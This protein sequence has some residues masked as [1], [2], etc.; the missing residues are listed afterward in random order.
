MWLIM[1]VRETDIPGLKII[2]IE[3]RCDNRGFFARSFCKEE[4]IKN[5]LEHEIVQCNISHNIQK[6]TLRGM[7]YQLPPH[8]EIKM[9]RC[10][11]GAIFDVVVDLRKDSA[12]Y[13][14]WRGFEIRADNYSMLY[15]PKGCAHGYQTMEDDTTVLYMVTEFYHPECERAIRWNDP[16][17]NI[18][19]PLPISL[20]SEK[21]K[22]YPDFVP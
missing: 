1:I 11:E 21:D 12:T 20:I 10:M 17:I 18:R 3:P 2:D 5:Q 19:W 7:H 13:L 9:V 6:G 4:F 14:W 8:G 15:I 22:S 16:S